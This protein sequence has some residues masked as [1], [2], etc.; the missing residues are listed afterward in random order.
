ME[1]ISSFDGA[2]FRRRK[3]EDKAVGKKRGIKSSFSAYLDAE[4]T[5]RIE[6]EIGL[7][8]VREL[9]VETLLD[10]IHEIGEKLKGNPTL[11]II[12]RYKRAVKGFIQ[13]IVANSLEVEEHISG[14]NIL[15]RKRFTLI[16]VIDEKLEK[17]AAEIM[18]TQK[19]QLEILRRVDEM[20]GL[21]IDLV[22]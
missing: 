16:K 5:G 11:K 21:L 14:V 6:G 3:R 4:E 13:Y 18:K 9:P 20:Y 12:Q 10:E 17:L 8:P 22:G 1:R 15:K 2:V 7:D 19:D